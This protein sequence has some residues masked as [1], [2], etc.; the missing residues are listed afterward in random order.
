MGVKLIT[1]GAEEI[2]VLDEIKFDTADE[3]FEELSL[4]ALPGRIVV[5]W[6]N[7]VV[8]QHIS[9]PWNDITAREYIENG[10]IYWSALRYAPM[11]EYKPRVSKNDVVFL[12]RKVKTPIL[13]EVASILKKRLEEE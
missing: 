9:L 13:V 12:I 2:I 5:N 8:F 11:K 7:G 3:F 4:G 10:R 6:A 1:K